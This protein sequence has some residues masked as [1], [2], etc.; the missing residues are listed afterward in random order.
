MEKTAELESPNPD[1]INENTPQNNRVNPVN[2]SDSVYAPSSK[3]F[4]FI[5]DG[6]CL[7]DLT[8]NIISCN[9]AFRDIFYRES[10]SVSKEYTDIFAELI[11]PG[12]QPNQQLQQNIVIEKPVVTAK[13]KRMWI[14]VS[15]HSTTLDKGNGY[16]IC[17]RDITS[18]RKAQL[19]IE[20]LN[21]DLAL[22]GRISRTVGRSLA[23]TEILVNIKTAMETSEQLVGGRLL[24]YDPSIELLWQG[25]AWG[26]VENIVF[27]PVPVSEYYSEYIVSRPAVTPP[28]RVP[29]TDSQP[30]PLENYA[31]WCVPI[32]SE[33]EL[34]GMMEIFSESYTEFEPERR[35]FYQLLVKQIGTAIQN[36]RLFEEVRAS[37][38]RL[39][40]LSS[41]LVT[42][43]ESERKNLARDL[44]D[45]VGQALIALQLAI[46]L[47]RE[48]DSEHK[49]QMQEQQSL[50]FELTTRIRELI[51]DMRPGVLEDEGIVGGIRCQI[52]RLPQ[53][54]DIAVSMSES[55]I[56][57]LRFAPEVET[58]FF[59]IAQEALTNTIRHSGAS[60]VDVKLEYDQ[61]TLRMNIVD[62]GHGFDV[63][64][65][66]AD[67]G[68]YGLVGMYERAEA[69]NGSLSVDSTP[70]N[71]T[72][73]TF[74]VD[75]AP[76]H[77][78]ERSK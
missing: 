32:I 3:V 38:E 21:A 23:M 20:E 11:K 70:G 36:T 65:K 66:L 42:A 19:H 4:D 67:T 74:C 33:N 62:D 6:I 45:E 77:K 24:I 72:H 14:E 51:T 27:E 55:G 59:R 75:C 31:S 41:N 68:H 46:G 49:K 10:D 13:G 34:I 64:S 54:S 16:A 53:Q 7:T 18:T 17:I 26:V 28:K 40:T 76:L 37:R 15:A 43:V 39:K 57:N 52:N 63:Y 60:F 29:R 44:H 69:I 8:G 25:I 73:L 61:Q 58:V 78:G 9:R 71:G 2:I 5:T 56:G 30:T 12:C 50:V 35:A 47:S 48:P 22:L 1:D